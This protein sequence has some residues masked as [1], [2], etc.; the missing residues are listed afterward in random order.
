F[1]PCVSGGNYLTSPLVYEGRTLGRIILGPFIE[2][3]ISTLPE[4]LL[5]LALDLSKDELQS[6]WAEIPRLE[7]DE[8]LKLDA[9]VRSTLDLLIFSGLKAHMASSMHMASIQESFRELSEK[10]KKLQ[11]AYERLKELDRLKSNFLATVSH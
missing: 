5:A 2:P 3:A 10:N 9:H 4:G 7:R 6:A 1:V 11:E 8:A